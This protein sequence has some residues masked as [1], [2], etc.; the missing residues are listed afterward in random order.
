MLSANSDSARAN[1][2]V[3][4]PFDGRYGQWNLTQEDVDGV[5]VYRTALG[6][7]SAAVFAATA[8]SVSGLMDV[9]PRLY[10]AL[11]LVEA[12]A[13]GV[14]LQTIHI[15]MKP[16]HNTLKALWGAG[17][18][19]AVAL[20]ISPLLSTGGLVTEV[21]AH[22][23]LLLAVG[24]QFVSLTGLFFKEAICFG[25]TEAIALTALLPILTGGHFLGVFPAGVEAGLAL[26]F[27]STFVF[28]AARKLFLQPALDDLG[29][30]SIFDH[31]A[32][33]GEL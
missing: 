16:M 28:F 1:T 4:G 23:A 20:G 14:A 13:F 10:D 25:R 17:V 6:V 29:D 19:G 32:R 2:V 18:A 15:Y 33:G 8:I 5:K 9:S 21:Y 3:E 22:P 26:A 7:C 30:K 27:S 24:W 31:L 12:A 11:F